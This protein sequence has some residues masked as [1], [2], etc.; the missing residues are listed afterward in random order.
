MRILV[1]GD[2]IAQGFWDGQGG[3]V[4]RIRNKF[5]S[6]A[7]AGKNDGLP[8]IHN[9]GISGDNSKDLLN[10]FVNDYDSRNK[11]TNI[12][13]IIFAV[14][15]NDCQIIDGE[16]VSGSEE[17]IENISK[18][19]SLAKIRTKEII[20][21]GL[22]PCIEEITTPVSWDEQTHY[23]NERLGYFNNAL[24]SYCL[25]NKITFID[26]FDLFIDKMNVNT[27]LQDGLHPNEI[28]HNLIA[29]T[30]LTAI[31]QND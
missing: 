10:R 29:D 28:G 5:I 23:T 6:K 4:Q 21:V 1:F 17:Y 24:K 27:L 22:T 2:S 14:G 3:W 19:Y 9:L 15:T 7:I 16:P 8:D 13:T 30:V 20:F 31:K 12:G 11:F 25:D 26:L 18:I